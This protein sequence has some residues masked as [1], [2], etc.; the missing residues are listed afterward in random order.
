MSLQV[1]DFR[2]LVDLDR[3][4]VE[5]LENYLQGKE[6]RIGQQLLQ[7]IPHDY[8]GPSLSYEGVS[9]GK[10]SDSIDLFTKK[11]QLLL[12]KNIQFKKEDRLAESL[13]K[14]LNDLLWE[15][16]E[17]LEGCVTELFQQVRQVS[18]D[19]WTSSF[20]HVVQSLYDMLSHRIEDL[21][22]AIRRLEQPI[23]DFC[24]QY[25][26]SNAPWWERWA[27]LGI[28]SNLLKNLE[29]SKKYLQNRYS[30]FKDQFDEYKQLS[31][32]V[33]DRLEKM[34][35]YPVLALMD[36]A[37][38]N[39]YVDIFRF[40]KLIEVN[41]NPKGDLAQE[42]VRSLK[43]LRSLDSIIKN[44]RLYYRELKEALF[45]SS[46]EYKFL[47]REQ[48][49][50]SYG[51]G[52]SRLK[53][54]VAEYKQEL[55]ELIDT[56]S[57]YRSFIL[58]NDANPYV[59]SRWGFTERVVAPEPISATK[60]LNLAYLSEELKTNYDHFQ[61]ALESNPTTQNI[62]EQA[63]HLEIDRLLHEMGQ[64]LISH[65]M[66][67]DRAEHLLD[68]IKICDE[69]GSPSMDTIDYVQNALSK[70]IRLD[71]K[72][73][74]LHEYPAFHEYYRL[75]QG[76][77]HRYEDPSHAFRNERFHLFFEQIEEWVKKGDLF[78]HIHEIEL[79]I[80][81]MKTYLQDYLAAVQRAMRDR[82]TDPFLDET[83]EK[84]RQQ[85][86]EYRYIFGQFFSTITRDSKDGQQ[87][88]LQFLFVDQYFE[89]VENILNEMALS[90]SNDPQQRYQGYREEE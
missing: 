41:P 69:V 80:N 44:F 88:R 35:N 1:I 60:L 45:S 39:L 2:G 86:L 47:Y 67:R 58:N 43:Y 3:R 21:M 40:L 78:G 18:L 53:E 11:I 38:Q 30:M 65:S 15:Y 25:Q 20:A 42:S 10:L 52:V 4:V 16:T 75:H 6:S 55:V 77:T 36:V 14:E 19:K 12:Q 56:I 23:K 84:Y 34:R 74:V 50:T 31:A 89:T 49:S 90:W 32:K 9:S 57:G 27:T 51:E 59:R 17:V 73:H 62:Y 7:T 24:N 33:D 72:Y 48:D 26:Q 85:L 64:P 82:S 81:D 68:Q 79:D 37:D 63:A 76:M 61:K 87:L 28:D 46:L 13:T 83:V 66:M 22:W 29:Q 5:Q 71:W 70:A 8:F 54:K